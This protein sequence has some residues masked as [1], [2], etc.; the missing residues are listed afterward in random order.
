MLHR[1]GFSGR[2]VIG[3]LVNHGPLTTAYDLFIIVFEERPLVK[4][5]IPEPLYAAILEGSHGQP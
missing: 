3:D 4:S 1:C 2:S 5:H